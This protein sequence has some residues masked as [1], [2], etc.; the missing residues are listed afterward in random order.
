MK[1]ARCTPMY[2]LPYIDF[3]TQVPY[4]S[5]TAWSASARRVKSRS[6]LPANLSIAATSSGEIPITRAPACA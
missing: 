2:F 4:F 6:Y 1:V 5:A 3:S